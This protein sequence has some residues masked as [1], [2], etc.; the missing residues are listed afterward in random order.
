MFEKRDAG[1]YNGST[2]A[3]GALNLGSSPG[4][5]TILPIQNKNMRKCY[6][7]G[8]EENLTQDHIPPKNLFPLPRP[9]DLITIPCCKKCNEEFCLIDESFR[10]FVSAAIN[11][12]NSGSWIWGN[13]VMGS[14]F[15][16]SPKL[17]A[18]FRRNL[19]PVEVKLGDITIR[20]TTITYPIEKA[21]NYLIRL[22]KGFTYKYNP[23]IDYQEFSFKVKQIV[24]KQEI[25]NMLHKKFFY[26]EK[27]DG[28]FRMWRMYT[29]QKKTTGLFIFV[30]YDA[31]MFMIEV[32]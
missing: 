29:K 3:S 28:V 31:L 26:V 15:K 12:S 5:A 10:V 24:P 13:K 20:T 1:S 17:K 8:S 30:F 14:S 23:E 4:P 21:N 6:L 18:S 22:V 9:T 7:C 27:G 11:R 25:V 16:R 19:I 2:G 32:N